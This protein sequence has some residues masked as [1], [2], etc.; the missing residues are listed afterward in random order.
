MEKVI[1]V[2]D[3]PWPKPGRFDPS[4]IP[5]SARIESYDVGKHWW[6]LG[7]FLL[8]K[9]GLLIIDGMGLQ[10][11]AALAQVYWML[12]N[13]RQHDPAVFAEFEKTIA[14]G[15]IWPPKPILFGSMSYPETIS[16]EQQEELVHAFAPDGRLEFTTNDM[17]WDYGGAAKRVVQGS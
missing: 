5:V 8:T 7:Y 15:W 10:S 6:K 16:P 2:A 11:H 14:G 1:V 13:G 3:Q 12:M 17:F 9:E 4:V